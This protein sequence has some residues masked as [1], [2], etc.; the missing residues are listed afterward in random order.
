LTDAQRKILA[1]RQEHHLFLDEEGRYE[2][3]PIEEIR[4][5]AEGAVK[6]YRF[7]RAGRPQDTYLLLWAVDADVTLR[8]AVGPDRLSVMRPF[9]TRLAVEGSGIET[10]VA[11]GDR[12]YLELAGLEA[13]GAER[14]LRESETAVGSASGS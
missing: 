2:L 13:A 8:L 7:H 5:V 9:G 11:V 3:V 6:A 12:M 10:V 1:N 4:G 14:V